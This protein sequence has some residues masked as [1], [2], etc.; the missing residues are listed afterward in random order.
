MLEWVAMPS[1]RGSSQPRELNP[2]SLSFL[3]WQVGSKTSAAWEAPTPEQLFFLHQ[4][5][6]SK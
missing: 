1:S 5:F 6:L 2:L 4:N 3:C